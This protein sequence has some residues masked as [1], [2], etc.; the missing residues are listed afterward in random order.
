MHEIFWDHLAPFVYRIRPPPIKQTENV[1][2]IEDVDM[3]SEKDFVNTELLDEKYGNLDNWVKERLKS[4]EEYKKEMEVWKSG[5]IL[6]E[7]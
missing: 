2:D 4:L 6:N 1:V 5:G 3:V 7:D